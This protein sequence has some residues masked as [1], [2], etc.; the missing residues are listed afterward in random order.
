MRDSHPDQAEMLTSN[1]NE[2]KVSLR[3]MEEYIPSVDFVPTAGKLWHEIAFQDF[4][5]IV[6]SGSEQVQ[7]FGTFEQSSLIYQEGEKKDRREQY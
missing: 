1:N 7:K 6:I 5:I 3:C 4:E 2:M